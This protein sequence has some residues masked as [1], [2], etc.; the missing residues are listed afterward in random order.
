MKNIWQKYL[1]VK[2][3]EFPSWWASLTLEEKE[4]WTKEFN[5]R[6]D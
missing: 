1:E 3:G 6:N 4:E 2:G 5:K